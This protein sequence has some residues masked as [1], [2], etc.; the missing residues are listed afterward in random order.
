MQG[1][2]EI[3]ILTVTVHIY[4]ILHVSTFHVPETDS[5]LTHILI[6]IRS[7]RIIIP[8]REIIIYPHNERKF[9]IMKMN[10]LSTVIIPRASVFENQN[11]SIFKPHINGNNNGYCRT[12]NHVVKQYM[13]LGQTKC[14]TFVFL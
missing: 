12:C 13:R 7:R 10:V 9:E 5:T 6:I 14:H 1:C 3:H 11:N 8:L 2:I 4:F